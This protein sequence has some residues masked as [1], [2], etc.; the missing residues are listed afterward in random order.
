MPDIPGTRSSWTGSS[1]EPGSQPSAVLAASA[2]TRSFVRVRGR[3]FLW[4]R[5]PTPPRPAQAG[6]QAS[7]GRPEHLIRKRTVNCD[8][9]VG[10]SRD[11]RVLANGGIRGAT[12]LS[13]SGSS[14]P[15]R[16][17]RSASVK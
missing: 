7:P 17:R 8:E 11:P 10:G 13:P 2:A 15:H 1:T 6:C 12:T 9:P 16:M 14:L 4:D 5:C 3:W